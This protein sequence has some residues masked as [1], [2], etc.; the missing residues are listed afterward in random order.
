[1]LEIRETA[2]G[3]ED[4]DTKSIS[5]TLTRLDEE[6][7]YWKREGREALKVTITSSSSGKIVD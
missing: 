5:E 7:D 6:E 1:M 3:L 2:Y 4:S